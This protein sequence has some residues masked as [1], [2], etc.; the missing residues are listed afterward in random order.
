M[1]VEEEVKRLKEEIMRL[2]G[3]QADGTWKVSAASSALVLPRVPSLAGQVQGPVERARGPKVEFPADRGVS[4]QPSL[5]PYC[6]GNSLAGE[7]QG[8]V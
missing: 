5:S 6:S 2:G 1:N 4:Q 8:P 7:V 3:E